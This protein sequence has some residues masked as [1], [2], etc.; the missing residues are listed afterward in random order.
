[1]VEEAGSNI[2]N[3]VQNGDPSGGDFNNSTTSA[4][5]SARR[6]SRS[7]STSRVP[8]STTIRKTA[9]RILTDHVSSDYPEIKLILEEIRATNIGLQLISSLPNS[10]GHPDMTAHWESQLEAIYQREMRY[11]HFM[12]PMTEG[13]QQLI[14]DVESVEFSGLRGLGK[15]PKQRGKNNK[16]TKKKA[17]KGKNK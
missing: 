11:D 16:F 9:S 15:P 14:D 3:L 1:M 8:P 4:S 6:T 12:Q 17:V 2:G 5:T 13:L 10:M 7:T